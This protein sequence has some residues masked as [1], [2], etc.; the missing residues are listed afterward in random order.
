MN[1]RNFLQSAAVTGTALYAGSHLPAIG[2]PR[3]E[4]Q[5]SF[6]FMDNDNIMII[7]ELFGG[8]DGLNTI[9]P[10]DNDLY[11][12]YRPKVAIAKEFASRWQ[13]S[14]LYFHPA[15]VENIESG[16]FMNMMDNGQLAVIENVGYDKPTLSHFRSKEIW[17]SGINNKDPKVKLDEGWLGRFIASRLPDYPY[18]LPEHP[19]CVSVGGTVPLIFKSRK[20]HMGI[21][22]NDAGSF[23]EKSAGLKPDF[24]LMEGDGYYPD[25]FNFIYNIAAQSE[26]YGRAVTDAYE[27]GENIGEYSDTGLSAKFKT[28]AKLIS[29]G[30]KSKVFYVGLSNFDSHVQQMSEALAG[31]HPILLNEL[32]SAISEFTRDA[33]LQ[34]FG[35]RVAGMT[36]SEFGR[37]VKDNG[38]RGTDHGT[39][40]SMFVW[41]HFDYLNGAVYGDLPDLADLERG[42]LKHQYDFRMVYADFLEKWFGADDD[43][44]DELFQEN[45]GTLNVL[46]T[47]TSSVEEQALTVANPEG[48]KVYPN[49]TNGNAR[50]SFNITRAMDVKV[51][52]Y[53]E[54]GHRIY[55]VYEGPA[56]MGKMDL[57]VKIN[58]SG[59]YMVTVKAGNTRLSGMIIVK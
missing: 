51:S 35:E 38:S 53:T 12:Q 4:K 27:A 58:T 22:V 34:G 15:L 48:I 21:A 42:N 28:I 55:D 39:A 8:N 17:Q 31:Q 19:V 29:G 32:A 54:T 49:P 16:G 20:G 43:E 40:S 25:E 13:N 36:T 57:P 3:F 59:K 18:I 47:R 45:I 5:E 46:K 26:Q 41:G 44:I 6:S 33:T 37:R 9:I 14:Q 52:V 50:I 2:K 10:V 24:P 23:A 56:N 11:Y 7:V 30:L 1:R